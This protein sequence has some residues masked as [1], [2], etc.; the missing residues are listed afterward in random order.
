MITHNQVL[1]SLES[2]SEYI[3]SFAGVHI[4]IEYESEEVHGFLSLLFGD[5]QGVPTC[6]AETVLWITVA[7]TAGEFTLSGVGGNPFS[8]IL[9]IRFAAVVFDAVIF[10]V[11]NKNDQGI[12]FHAGAVAY[13]DKIILLPGES[14]YGKSSMTACLVASGCSYLTDE[15]FFI[16]INDN[17]PRLSFTRPLC[18]KS[19]S[20]EAILD[21][22]SERLLQSA[23]S[24]QYGYVIPHR[25]LN[26]DFRQITDS[27]SLIL[28]P[29]Y[30]ADA[31]LIIEKLSPAQVSTQLMTC[32]VNGR[33]LEAHGFPQVVEIARSTPAYRITFSSFD[34][35]EEAMQDLFERLGWT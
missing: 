14:G 18:I 17:A 19:G 21:L 12:A 13:E 6:E 26:S 22:L 23:L 32:D 30:V 28:I 9:G 8:G 15:L 2:P 35:I 27:P 7:E 11:L 16:P 33:N 31:P 24:D 34:G 1:I 3:V 25:L 5:L 29:K 10:N 20:A 4:A